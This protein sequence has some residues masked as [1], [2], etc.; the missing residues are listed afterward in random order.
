MPVVPQVEILRDRAAL[1]G[2]HAKFRTQQNVAR[3]RIRRDELDHL[4]LESE[5]AQ[6]HRAEGVREDVA[7]PLAQDAMAQHAGERRVRVR[8]NRLLELMLA[9]G[10]RHD[11]AG[12]PL[13]ALREGLV[14]RRVAR[15]EGDHHVG[16]L[17][18]E[19]G[20]VEG[21][22]IRLREHHLAHEV[23]LLRHFRGGR[24]DIV[25]AVDADYAHIRHSERLR[26]VEV[27]C[28]REIG[29]PA[30]AVDDGERFLT[31]LNLLPHLLFLN[32]LPLQ[33]ILDHLEEFVHLIILAAHRGA[34]LPLAVGKADHAQERGR[35]EGRERRLLHA[36]VRLHL[37]HTV[38]LRAARRH[39]V[40]LPRHTH[41]EVAFRSHQMKVARPLLRDDLL[42][43]LRRSVGVEVLHADLSVVDHLRLIARLAADCD[44]PH[45]DAE[46]LAVAPHRLDDLHESL[47]QHPRADFLR[48]CGVQFSSFHSSQTPSL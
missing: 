45:R 33:H 29:L 4:G 23:K 36:V 15:M 48:Q 34:D 1:P 12:L 43:P 40:S 7:E 18:A 46:R 28:Q 9:A 39:H 17:E 31:P 25:P 41:V 20:D 11:V 24:N 16:A 22:Q 19:G 10:R 26:E 38:H 21:H 2:L 47:A 44:G 32:P 42:K 5:D 27:E 30:S 14:G 8:T 35:V 13:H 3:C 37:H 6:D